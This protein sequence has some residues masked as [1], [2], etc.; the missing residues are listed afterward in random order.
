MSNTMEKND[1]WAEILE[2]YIE[3]I[4]ITLNTTR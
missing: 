3:Y 2:L 1:F 4:Y